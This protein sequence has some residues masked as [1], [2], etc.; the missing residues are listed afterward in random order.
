MGA[1]KHDNKSKGTH[2]GASTEVFLDAG[3]IPATSTPKGG[4][5]GPA[6]FLSYR[7]PGLLEV[8]GL[9]KWQ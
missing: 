1:L 2:V 8:C 9:T 4:Q 5:P 7:Q 6:F 3:S